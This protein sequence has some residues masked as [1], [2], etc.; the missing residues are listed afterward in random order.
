M[1]EHSHNSQNEE[2]QKTSKAKQIEGEL[3]NKK[4]NPDR[5]AILFFGASDQ[6]LGEV[7][8]TELRLSSNLLAGAPVLLKDPKRLFTLKQQTQQGISIQYI[9]G[10]FDLIESG[11]IAVQPT[12]GYYIK[13]Q[14]PET[15]EAYLL[16][17]MGYLERRSEHRARE[18]GLVLPNVRPG[19]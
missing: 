14:S 2:K 19:R 17:L 1:T 11:E 4:I 7:D 9:I 15:Y 8:S 18:S 12:A 13:N 6:V 16:L 5:L 3:R 10:D